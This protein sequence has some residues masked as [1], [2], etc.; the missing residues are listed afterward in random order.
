MKYRILKNFLHLSAQILVMQ[1]YA[2][3][4]RSWFLL[5]I[6]AKVY[7]RWFVSKWHTAEIIWWEFE[8]FDRFK[9]HILNNWVH[10]WMM[11]PERCRCE[12]WYLDLFRWKSTP[13]GIIV[14]KSP[15]IFG[16]GLAIRSLEWR[17]N[18]CDGVSNHQPH[19]SLL[20][21]LFRRRSKKPSV[22]GD[23]WIPR[24]N[25]QW[26]GKYISIWWRHHVEKV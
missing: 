20:N 5:V 26:R 12:W 16:D 4:I 9:K 21:R 11:T 13:C 15:L 23:R 18:G 25:G 22:T 7:N 19:D 1:C 2:V 14:C 24:T 10:S 3:T 17:H 8:L 6:T